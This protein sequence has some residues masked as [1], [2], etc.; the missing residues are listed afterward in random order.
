MALPDSVDLGIKAL[1][2][3]L[4]G[5]EKEVEKELT[6]ELRRLGN[7]IR[8]TIRGSTA[9]PYRTGKLRKS[10]K[11]SVRRKGV[12]SLYSNEPHAPIFEFGGVIKPRGTRIKIPGT[13]FVRGTVVAISD[14]IDEE[15]ADAFDGVAR[16]HGFF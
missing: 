12:V 16:R 2:G 6:K 15:I 8:D 1:N 14:A 7:E 11:T 5:I 13:N 3:S 10:V 4:R 9:D